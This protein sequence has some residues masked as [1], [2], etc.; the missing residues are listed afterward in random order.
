MG[1][2]YNYT[3]TVDPPLDLSIRWE[4][5]RVPPPAC[6]SVVS[7]GIPHKYREHIVYDRTQTYPEFLLRYRRYQI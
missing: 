6:D 4:D 3:Q 1:R 5:R 7:N 2:V